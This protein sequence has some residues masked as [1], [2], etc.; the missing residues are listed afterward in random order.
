MHYYAP[1]VDPRV[2]LIRSKQM[3]AY[4]RR[5]QWIEE[6]LVRK[7]FLC[8]RHPTKKSAVFLPTL[9]D[10]DDYGLCIFEAVTELSRIEDRFAGD[11]LTDLLAQ[12]TDN[13]EAKPALPA[14]A[15]KDDA[16]PQP[17]NR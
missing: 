3:I 10:G 2:K 6:G 13:A 16:L 15:K 4:L 12:P 9:E 17:V 8:F 11:V 5:Q 1:W 14:I 7:H